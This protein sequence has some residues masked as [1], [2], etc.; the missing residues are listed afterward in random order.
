MK[1]ILF[2]GQRADNKKWVEGFYFYKDRTQQHAIHCSSRMGVLTDGEFE[3]IP[4]TIGQFTGL[5]DKNGKEIFEGDILNISWLTPSTGGYFQSDD[6]WC[7]NEVIAKV[8]FIGDRFVYIKKDGKQ[9]SIKNGSTIEIIGNI[10][11]NPEL[12]NPKL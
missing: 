10:H 4:E 5:L 9:T 6:A 8:D 2:R 12:L 1:E 11:D 7:E 3:I